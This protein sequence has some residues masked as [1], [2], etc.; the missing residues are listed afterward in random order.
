MAC[1]AVTSCA[2]SSSSSTIAARWLGEGLAE[3]IKRRT[4][5]L[6]Q[7]LLP[8]PLHAARMRKRGFNQAQE[9][10]RVLTRKL[11]VPSHPDWAQRLHDTPDQIGLSAGQ[12]RR[13][14]KDAFKVDA[15]IKG[16]RVALIDDVMTTG[17]TLT[18]LTRACI[19][20]GA[21]GVELWV[22][23]RAE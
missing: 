6:P 8:V 19:K 11:Q 15:R 10:A 1:S 2:A 7:I 5:P 9:L 13:N 23:A 22:A 16:M 18:E 20:A 21:S 3:T 17:S 4:Q 12:R 14:V